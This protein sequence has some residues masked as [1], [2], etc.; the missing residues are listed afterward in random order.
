M[1]KIFTFKTTPRFSDTDAYGIVHHSNHYKMLEEA[2]INYANCVLD[3]SMEDFNDLGYKFP[4]IKSECNY[5][6]PIYYGDT[7]NIDII[8][9]IEKAARLTFSYT[10]YNE[11][12][13]LIH[14]TAKTCHVFMKHDGKLCL[15]YP[16]WFIAK[17][18]LALTEY[19]IDY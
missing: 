13:K 6:V 7:L 15:T 4:V 2:R 17:I 1:S 18:K 12:T 14:A 11:R 8:F 16:D 5:K 9:S 3:L 10:I 19:Q